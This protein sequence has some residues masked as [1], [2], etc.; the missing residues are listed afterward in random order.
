MENITKVVREAN[1][2]AILKLSIAKSSKGLSLFAKSGPGMNFAQFCRK[3]L[4]QFVFGG[5]KCYQPKKAEYDGIESVFFCSD[6][7]IYRFSVRGLNNDIV[8]NLMIL[9]AED[10]SAGVNFDMGC[11]PITNTQINFYLNK[12]KED[13]KMLYALFLKPYNVSVEFST[14]L[15]ETDNLH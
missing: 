8:P 15:I 3:D 4:G 2:E 13:V 11:Y 1:E 10:L 12:L 9:L 14:K 5:V 7:E 6:E